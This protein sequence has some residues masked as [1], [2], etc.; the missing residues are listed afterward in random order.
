MRKKAAYALHEY[1]REDDGVLYIAISSKGRTKLG[2]LLAAGANLPVGFQERGEFA[3]LAAFIRYLNG[4]RRELVRHERGVEFDEALNEAV[5]EPY[6]ELLHQYVR[7][8]THS[9]KAAELG[10]MK[11]LRDNH[12]PFAV[13][14]AIDGEM[15]P[16]PLPQWYGEVL[17]KEKHRLHTRPPEKIN[18]NLEWD[19]KEFAPVKPRTLSELQQ[20]YV[21]LTQGTDEMVEL[22]V[23][24]EEYDSIPPPLRR[25]MGETLKL[26]YAL[27]GRYIKSPKRE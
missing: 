7:V 1:D 26:Q 2:R 22:V 25:M 8:M 27:E 21:E 4:D 23:S 9:P 12:L 5:P 6:H 3:S 18:K 13:Y 19:E 10:L 11:L 20:A 17:E 16:M 14:Q 15:V 24:Q